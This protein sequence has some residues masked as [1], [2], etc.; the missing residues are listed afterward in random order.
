MEEKFVRYSVINQKNPREIVMLRG[1][2]CK[3][4]KCRFCDYHLDFSKNE[5]ENFALNKQVLSSVTGLYHSLEVINSG[6]FCD[7][8]TK[9]LELI[10][11]TCTEK[12]ISILRFESHWMHR[13]QIAELKNYFKES[14]IDVHIKMGVETF[15]ETFRENLLC[16]GM[17]HA[18][19]EEIAEYAD[20]VCLLF[21]LTG[22]TEESMRRDIEV[23]LQYFD[24]ICINI[25]NENTTNVHPDPKVIRCFMETLFLQYRNEERVDILIENT[26]FGVGE[27]EKHE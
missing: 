3:W 17:K 21:G 13:K 10:R 5:E 25:M 16:K 22:Q 12:Y 4:K 15:D 6:S 18:S 20:E 23:G 19:P 1:S 26:E 14:G 2:G 8:D 9:T 7:L 24:R 27:K 11:Q